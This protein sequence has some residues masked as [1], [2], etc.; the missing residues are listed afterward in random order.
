MRFLRPEEA[1]HRPRF[2]RPGSARAQGGLPP[3]SHC[4]GVADRRRFTQPLCP[5]RRDSGRLRASHSAAPPASAMGWL[6]DASHHAGQDPG[7]L[8]HAP[9]ARV[10]PSQPL[11]VRDVAR[12]WLGPADRLAA[13]PSQPL[14]V[15]GLPGTGLP[16]GW[17]R[18]MP[19][20]RAGGAE[21]DAAGHWSQSSRASGPGGLW[22]PWS[23]VQA[24]AGPTLLPGKRRTGRR[25][26][27][28][29]FPYR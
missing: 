24:A 17:L 7:R 11:A 14:A 27:G 18:H 22:P 2:R 26:A 21:H 29:A 3:V 12:H 8:D 28:S 23:A 1:A 19:A 10:Q 6:P 13:Q 25:H 4:Q 9:P 20:E 15:R 16:I 5:W